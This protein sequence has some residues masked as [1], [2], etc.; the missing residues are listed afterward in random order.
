MAH[1]IKDGMHIYHREKCTVC[2]TC[3]E[4]CYAG[5]MELIG[6]SMTVEQVMDEV[7]RDRPFYE[8]SNGGI[9]LSGGEPLLQLEFARS[10]LEYCKNEGIHTAIETIANCKWE[11][12][13]SLLPITDLIMMDIK[14]LDPNKHKEVTGASNKTILENAVRIA[15]IDKPVI[16]RVPIV[17]SVNDTPE[18]I[19]AIADF[20]IELIGLRKKSFPQKNNIE[21]QLE[22]L[23]FHQLATDKYRSLGFDYRASGLETPAKQKIIDLKNIARNKDIHI[24]N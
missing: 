17:P 15:Q 9:T 1:E 14:H 16:F 10:I 3:I 24:V 6:K 13:E 11:D 23:P 19:N 8:T 21:I 18:E 12:F 2:G 22:F 20:V 4:T 5:T 7:I